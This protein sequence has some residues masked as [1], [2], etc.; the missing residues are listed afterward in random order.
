MPAFTVPH[1]HLSRFGQLSNK[2]KQSKLKTSV[3]AAVWDSQ[4][5]ELQEAGANFL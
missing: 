1:T 2:H 5:A 3:T 4:G